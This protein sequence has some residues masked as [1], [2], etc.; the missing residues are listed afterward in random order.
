MESAE[1]RSLIKS[2]GACC[3]GW[4]KLSTEEALNQA[5]RLFRQMVHRDRV[6]HERVDLAFRRI[7][8]YWELMR[9][10]DRQHQAPVDPVR[11]RKGNS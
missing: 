2:W 9:I 10:D 4:K 7:D 5:F 3:S 1:D 8:E 11:E 6:P